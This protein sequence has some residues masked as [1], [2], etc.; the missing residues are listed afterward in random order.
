MIG[1]F[2]QNIV[3]R[4]GLPIEKGTVLT[5]EWLDENEKIAEAWLNYWLLY[6]D[7]FLDC[8]KRIDDIHF[9]LMFYQRI[10][11]RASMRYRYH[12][13]TATRATSKSFIAFL[14]SVLRATFL[15][16]SEI[17]IVA[18]VK[19]TV[20]KIAKQK[21]AEIWDHWPLLRNELK[22]RSDDGEQG[23]KKGGDYYELLFK[24]GSKISVISKDTARGIR[25]NA[26]IVEESATMEEEPYNEIILPIMNIPRKEVDGSLNPDEPLSPQTFITTA[27]PK[28]CFMYGKLIE[29]TVMEILRPDEYF[30]WGM[31]YR[32]PVK[33]GLLQ[34]K[35]LDEQRFSNTMSSDAFARESMSIWTGNSKEAWF[36][37]K[38]LNRRRTLLHCE[39]KAQENPSN[40]NTFYIA[41]IDVARYDVNSAIAVFKVIPGKET[42]KKKLIYLEVIHGANFITDQAPRI[43]K[44]IQLYNPK[45]VVIDGNGMGAGLMDAMSVPSVDQTTGEQFPPY[46]AFNNEDH[47]PP[48][49]KNA[50]EEPIPSLNAIIYDLKANA[51][52]NGLMHAN[53][54]AQISNGSLSLLADEKIVK[55][56]LMATKK[57]QKMSHYDKR[58][59]LMPYEMTSR[60]ID[61]MNNLKLKPTGV[62]NQ[63]NIEQISRSVPKDRFSAVEYGLWRIKYYEDSAF[64]KS[65][66]KL[67][68]QFA[69][70]SPRKRR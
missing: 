69:F 42:F 10:A 60:L 4:D 21:F 12:F 20:I 56:K 55:D 18:D 47:L 31:D 6:P 67:N 59:F 28:T 52:N 45:E 64:R 14:S 5:K 36:D 33:Y 65:K 3:F 62:Q 40:P 24:N 11:L 41:A 35:Q 50:S 61:E 49:K 22:T 58:V 9:N 54:F 48:D 7:A 37:S 57:G 44:I 68:G 43:K 1:T 53:I 29:L 8:I 63:I 25:A 23:E 39:R 51:S 2:D 38:M 19:G 15:P 32:V 13:L 34:K 17:I 27:G 16:K 70:F 30:I 26:A 66:N 46:Y